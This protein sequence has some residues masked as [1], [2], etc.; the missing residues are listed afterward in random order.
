MLREGIN[1]QGFALLLELV[2]TIPAVAEVMDGLTMDAWQTLYN[3]SIYYE[4]SK[5]DSSHY[6][7]TPSLIRSTN[8]EKRTDHSHQFALL[9]SQ[10][11]LTVDMTSRVSC[12]V[13]S[14]IDSIVPETVN[15]KIEDSPRINAKGLA[16]M[17]LGWY[18]SSSCCIQKLIC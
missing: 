18:P 2:S 9:P 10:R 8:V 15:T 4:P 13:G 16:V 5:Y 12:V 1:T 3:A 6:G 14:M 17:L 11:A 7:I